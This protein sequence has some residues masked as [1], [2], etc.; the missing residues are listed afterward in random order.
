MIEASPLESVGTDVVTGSGPVMTNV[1]FAPWTGP[2]ESVT[3]AVTVA[4]SLPI[5]RL[6]AG[7]MVRVGFVPCVTASA[8]GASTSEAGTT[9][10]PSRKSIRRRAL[11]GSPKTAF[12]EPLS[13]D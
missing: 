11:N 12:M 4:V 6:C 7:V 10:V 2:L 1:T 3:V 8:A 9:S 5:V 13:D